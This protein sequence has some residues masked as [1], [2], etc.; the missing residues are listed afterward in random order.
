MQLDDY[1][2]FTLLPPH[3]SCPLSTIS[4][5]TTDF[6]GTEKK[7]SAEQLKSSMPETSTYLFYIIIQSQVENPNIIS[8]LPLVTTKNSPFIFY[9]AFLYKQQNL[10]L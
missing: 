5:I 7:K 9:I 10:V 3:L 6:Y 1:S 2:N 8:T 4:I